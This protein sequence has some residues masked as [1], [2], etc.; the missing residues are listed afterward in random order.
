MVVASAKRSSFVTDALNL[1][2]QLQSSG[3]G[4][5]EAKITAHAAGKGRRAHHKCKVEVCP[6]RNDL[7]R[8]LSAEISRMGRATSIRRGQVGSGMGAL[9]G[10]FLQGT[11]STHKQ[12]WPQ[13][14]SRRA[15]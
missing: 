4:T 7:S 11:S 5:G 6:C 9:L 15:L 10:S 8:T 1:D 12:C 14:V 13:A 3:S 2:G